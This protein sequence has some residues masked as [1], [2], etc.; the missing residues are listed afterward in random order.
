MIYT[1]IE[2]HDSDLLSIT[3]AD[4]T[5]VLSV[6]AYVHRWQKVDSKWLGTGWSQAAELRILSAALPVSLDS[7]P[8]D[9]YGG[10]LVA[11]P[12]RYDNVFPVPLV[13]SGEVRLTLEVL[14][15][16]HLEYSGNGFS[17]ALVGVPRFVE[18]LPQEW[19]PEG[20]SV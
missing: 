7:A 6:R 19:Q 11:G 5:L 16:E 12:T 9:I 10:E 1:S 17:A 18:A 14:R 2:L 15:A 3:V 8:D 13:F 4:T 20:D